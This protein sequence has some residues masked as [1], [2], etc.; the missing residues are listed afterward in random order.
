MKTSR[1]R[2]PRRRAELIMMGILALLWSLGTI[3]IGLLMV[4]LGVIDTIPWWVGF[5]TGL[6]AGPLVS[7]YTRRKLNQI[8]RRKEV[9][10]ER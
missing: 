2:T 1:P 9:Q 4:K 10:D 7:W 6:P 5:V 8:D 3:M